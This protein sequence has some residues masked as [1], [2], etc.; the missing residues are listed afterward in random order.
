[1]ILADTSAVVQI[2]RDKGGRVMAGVL[3]RFPGEYLAIIRPTELEFM[4]GARDER[5]WARLKKI[6]APLP[7]V[8]LSNEDWEAA[9][10]IDFDMRRRGLTVPSSVDFCVAQAA[11]T[12]NL[13]LLHRDRGFEKIRVVRKSLSLIWLD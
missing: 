6:L 7:R 3:S 13:P 8:D 9:A 1:M 12:H 10:R 2:A 5:N 4:R 11:L